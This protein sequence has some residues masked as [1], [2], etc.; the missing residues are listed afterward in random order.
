MKKLA[1][2]LTILFPVFAS[3]ANLN[4]VATIDSFI[5]LCAKEKDPVKRHNY[6]HM[7]DRYS[8]NQSADTDLNK[9]IV[10]V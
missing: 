5:E 2:I 4:N 3:A 6:C 10:T 9:D 7:L 8:I 1:L